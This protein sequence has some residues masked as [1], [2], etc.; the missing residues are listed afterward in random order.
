MLLAPRTLRPRWKTFAS[1]VEG[2]GLEEWRRIQ[3]QARRLIRENG[4]TYNVYGDPEGLDR[5]WELDPLPLVIDAAEWR[6]LEQGL[7]QRGRLLNAI[8][9]DL[10]GPQRLL[11]ERL[12]PPELV[13]GH[14][15]FLRPCIGLK[16]P[17]GAYLHIGA[18]ELARSPDGAW[19]VLSDRTQNPS[20]AGY[21]LENRMVTRR[22]LTQAFDECRVVRHAR[23]F[24]VMRE[25]L[26]GLAPHDRDNP[27]IVVLTPGPYNET[28]FEHSYLA[29]YLGYPLVEGADLTVRD[30]QVYLKTL[31]G[32]RR[33]DVI[34]R[35]LD[36]DFCDP[37]EFRSESMLGVPG[38]VRAAHAGNVAVANAL[39][40][41]LLE[42]AGLLPFLPVLAKHLLGEE[43]ILP[44][45]ATWWCG[46][47]AERLYVEENIRNIVVKHAFSYSH[48]RAWWGESLSS[49]ERDA[50]VA[51]IRERPYEFVGQEKIH[52][53]SAPIFSGQ[54]LEPRHVILRA[55]LVSSRGSYEIMPGGMTRVSATPDSVIV[56]MQQGGGSKD[57]WVLANGEG[58]DVPSGAAVARLELSRGERILSSRVADNLFWLGRYV[59][60][61]EGT[62]RMLRAAMD[63]ILDESG[64]G[65]RPEVARLLRIMA[66]RGQIS[67]AFA[68]FPDGEPGRRHESELA[69]SILD[70]A[71]SDHL[72]TTLAS[73][74]RVAA[75]VQ[76]R[77]SPD[78]W[79]ILKKLGEEM[80]RADHTGF[81]PI[82]D[83]RDLLD[84]MI[85][86]LAAYSGLGMESMTRGQGWRFLDM[87]RRLERAIDGVALLRGT[88][89]EPIENEALLL[90]PLLEI[91]ESI[92]TYRSRYRSGLQAAPV[93][94]LLMTD[95][96]NPRSIVFQIAALGEHLDHLPRD[97]AVPVRDTIDRIIL[98]SLTDLRL[99]D[100]IA[101]CEEKDGERPGLIR[102]L[103]CL[104]AG[105]PVFSDEITRQYLSHA[106]PPHPL[107]P[108][109]IVAAD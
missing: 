73:L 20:G 48:H 37:L 4:V 42:A 18:V 31:Q 35:K 93:L 2:M 46:Q 106:E 6:H 94:D 81:E 86:V 25:T 102:H 33:V 104:Q 44:S 74:Y 22:V 43:I 103:D 38:L 68:A 8:L 98:A 7:V 83:R 17:R 80:E 109:R 105:M 62:V 63:R 91:M 107:S 34:L 12:L 24:G 55:H 71:R 19:W 95:E 27:Q 108:L 99:A 76:D 11:K 57:T 89:C 41:G 1:A 90:E 70:D 10:Y 13:F 14:P 77:I 53:S 32:L 39:G 26:A 30:G 58:H 88:L 60:R 64:P 69:A 59:E 56:S 9:E 79:R 97:K 72:R 49:A 40:S 96:S 78:G 52:L 16:V 92:M 66:R 45:V 47:E 29:R 61:A 23:F 28:Y 21:A 3:D 85:V 5:P 51:R 54:G 67:P 84:R 101:L 82:G 65:G 15:G 75:I 87:G 50:L 100:P 36:D